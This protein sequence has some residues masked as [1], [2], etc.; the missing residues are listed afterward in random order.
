MS[1]KAIGKAQA[2]IGQRADVD[3]DDAKLLGTIELDGAAKQAEAGII[4]EILDLNTFCSERCGDRLL[5]DD[6]ARR[7]R[8]Y[9]L[10]TLL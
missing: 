10:L 7:G 9:R 5:C 6:R 4:D 8:S 2:E 3:G 1:H